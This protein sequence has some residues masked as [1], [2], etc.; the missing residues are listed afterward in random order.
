MAFTVGAPVRLVVRAAKHVNPKAT[1]HHT[2]TRPKKHTPS[3]RNRKKVEYP[4]LKPEE[5]PPLMTVISK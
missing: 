1:K 4:A 3:D 2:K 5:I